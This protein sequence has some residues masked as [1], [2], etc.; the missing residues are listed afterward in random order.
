MKNVMGLIFGNIHDKEL[1]EM[2]AGRTLGSLPFGGRFRLID[3]ALS[4]MSNSGIEK[5]GIITRSNYQSLMR[6]VGSG[7]SWDLSRKNGGVFFLPP[8]G[9]GMGGAYS[10][11]F[12]ALTFN[13]DFIRKSDEQY[14][15]MSDCD[16]V[17]NIDFA[18]VLDFHMSRNADITVIYRKKNIIANDIKKRITFDIDSDGKVVASKYI[19]MPQGVHNIYTDMLVVNR[20]LLLSLLSDE[21]DYPIQSFSSDVIVGGVGNYSIYGYELQGYFAG[22]DSM[23]NYFKHSM[24][25]LDE[26][27]RNALF[28]NNGA[29]IIT[30]VRDS[31]PCKIGAD[32]EISNSLIADGCKVDGRV[33]NSILFRGV[34][35]KKGAV[36]QNSILFQHTV[37]ESD[38]RLN[39]VI[40][41]K[42]CRILEGRVLSG[43]STAPYFIRK[44][45]II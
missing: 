42:D 7:K 44:G 27:N 22:M 26:S 23:A 33:E 20:G 28:D 16:N 41:D 11:R 32:A 21:R 35:I 25:M 2:T 38:S 1:P 31:A 5:I 8:F 39:C 45:S 19:V 18:K 9:S 13:R 36:V 14:V 10:S 3:F 34:E 6:H 37:V 15:V 12:E 29:R 17:C 24:E 43:H 30:R 4:N 40:S